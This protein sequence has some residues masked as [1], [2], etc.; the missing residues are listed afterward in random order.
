MKQATACHQ[1]YTVTGV[2]ERN[3]THKNTF[4][5]GSL[6]VHVSARAS[7][8]CVAGGIF[9]MGWPFGKVFAVMRQGQHHG[10]LRV[11][12]WRG[13]LDGAGRLRWCLQ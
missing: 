12:S 3:A 13:I 7:Y 8:E 4:V 6:R 2:T 9:L 1:S 10:Q 5:W 11:C